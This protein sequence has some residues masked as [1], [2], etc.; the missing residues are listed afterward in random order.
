M[1]V[2]TVNFMSKDAS[3]TFTNSLQRTGFSV[4]KNHPIDLKLIDDV[5][6]EWNTFFSNKIKL[7][8]NAAR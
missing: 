5:Y 8:N 1:N 3:V 4:L 2:Q 6:N 7:C